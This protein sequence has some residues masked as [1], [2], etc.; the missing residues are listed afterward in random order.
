VS[1]YLDNAA[2]RLHELVTAFRRNSGTGTI[3]QAWSAVLGGASIDDPDFLRR[4]AYVF[5]LPEEIERELSQVDEGEFESDLA[6]RWQG[7]IPPRLGPA[8]FSGQQSGQISGSFDDASLMSLEYCSYVL[9]RYRPQRYVSD[10]EVERIRMLIEELQAEVT[11]Q[12]GLDPDL[13]DFLSFHVNAM[14]Q[15]LLDLAVRG[16]AALEDALDRAV[17]A[18]QR[19]TDLTV[20]ADSNSS[21]WTKFG[22]IIIAV[23]AVLQIA[24]SSLALPSQIRGELEGPPSPTPVVVKVIQEPPE[25]PVPQIAHN[26]ERV[27]ESGGSG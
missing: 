24:T 1:R 21:A 7:S 12:P 6:R 25:A 3:P 4:I 26:A 22:S 15:A 14:Q 20:K 5:R 23:A 2:G 27:T 11:D 17:G 16:P 9:H 8:F 18:A 10:S 19:R 13:R